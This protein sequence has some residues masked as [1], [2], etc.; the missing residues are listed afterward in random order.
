MHLMATFENNIE[1]LHVPLCEVSFG[2]HL[3]S[4]WRPSKKA[5]FRLKGSY[6]IA[7]ASTSARW[8]ARNAPLCA[9]VWQIQLGLLALCF[10]RASGRARA[11]ASC[12]VAWWSRVN[13]ARLN[14]CPGDEVEMA[15]GGGGPAY[16]CDGSVG[17]VGGLR[18]WTPRQKIID[19]SAIF[20]FA[21]L[22][23]FEQ[24]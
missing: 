10:V 7:R 9:A 22:N 20:L 14:Q 6:T 15:C 2:N 13:L 12:N 5:L 8:L 3:F 16:F 23:I 18:W 4:I 21:V 1:L 24:T 11:T 17:T 19:S